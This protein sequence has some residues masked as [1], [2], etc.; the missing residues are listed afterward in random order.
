MRAMIRSV[1]FAISSLVILSCGGSLSNKGAMP[2]SLSKDAISALE[3][4]IFQVVVPKSEPKDIEYAEE[5]PKHLLPHHIRTDDYDVVG[6]AFAVDREHLITAAHVIPIYAGVP[7]QRYYVRDYSGNVYSIAKVLGYSDKLDL[8]KLQ[9]SNL[10]KSVVPIPM[11][12][13][14]GVGDVVYT[15]GHALGQKSLAFRSGNIASF[16]PEPV[17]GAWEHIRYTAAASPGNSGGPLLDG[18]G[19]VIGVVVMRTAQENLNYAVPIDR[20]PILSPNYAD[21]FR[22]RI[23]ERESGLRLSRAWAHKTKLPASLDVLQKQGFRARINS[24]KQLR[25]EFERKYRSKIFPTDEKIL[26]DLRGVDGDGAFINILDR[27]SQDDPWGLIAPESRSWKIGEDQ[28]L[29]VA[30]FPQEEGY[31]DL[32][33]LHLDK[34]KNQSLES[35]LSNPRA[36]MDL[37]LKHVPIERD[38]WGTDIRVT[39]FGSPASVT[40]WRDELGRPWTT[41]VWRVYDNESAIWQCTPQPDGVLCTM[42]MPASQ[43]EEIV[44]YYSRIGTPRYVF[45]YTGTLKDWQEFLAL[46][47][48]Y[49][50]AILQNATLQLG[51]GRVVYKLGLAQG[52]LRHATLE[53]DG[54]LEVAVAYGSLNPL[55]LKVET[56][57][58]QVSASPS[59]RFVVSEWLEP[60]ST[61]REGYR[62]DWQR[63]IN[64]KPPFS[65]VPYQDQSHK[66]VTLLGRQGQVALGIQGSAK[67]QVHYRCSVPVEYNIS[68][69]DLVAACKSFKSGSARSN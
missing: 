26:A 63:L 17:D 47:A 8:M 33:V 58:W 42:I 56:L 28:Y 16:T 5:L 2:I 61:S 62:R 38:Y 12:T 69:S 6:T 19:R 18:R 67:S 22:P 4:G 23:G 29:K 11:G 52:E 9:I 39:T 30:G 27:S 1:V 43:H 15:V 50:P 51:K 65:V 46:P 53:P 59:W 44:E 54:L 24:Q 31:E 37:F 68:D 40:T 35:F 60:L 21:L 36:L 45:N 14:F 49:R 32:F 48:K 10:P 64:G 3:H 20:L 66:V 41:A 57:L 7:F 55:S 34:P 25:L 13:S